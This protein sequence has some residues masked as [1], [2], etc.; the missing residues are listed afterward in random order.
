MS[1]LAKRPTQEF[2]ARSKIAFFSE[3]LDIVRAAELCSSGKPSSLT[4]KLR[5]STGLAKDTVIEKATFGQ[6]GLSAVIVQRRA[7]TLQRKVVPTVSAKNCM[8]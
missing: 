6:S 4:I 1:G 3:L 7:K 8:D 5:S 2:Q